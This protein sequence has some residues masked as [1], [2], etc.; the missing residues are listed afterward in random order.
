MPAPVEVRARRSP[1]NLVTGWDDIVRHTHTHTAQDW[2]SFRK[3]R[4]RPVD[5][6]LAA[7]QA[8]KPQG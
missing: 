5:I 2:K 1:R 6:G 7:T 3:I 8:A 4:Y